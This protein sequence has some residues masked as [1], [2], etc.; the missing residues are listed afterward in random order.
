M[1]TK[2]L[3]PLILSVVAVFAYMACEEGS[4]G[5]Q[6]VKP[7]VVEHIEGSDL[8]HITLTE[9]AMQRLDVQTS[10][11]MEMSGAKMASKNMNAARL[12][13]RH[14]VVPYSAV[15]Y[16]PKGGT[17]VYVSPEPRLFVRERVEIDFIEGQ[18]ACLKKG[19]ELGV[20]V[21]SVGAA[22]LYGAEFEVG[23]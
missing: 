12:R 14:K 5:H 3:Y 9:K 11:V 18:N 7:A 22:E 6:M 1:Q 2:N 13:G 21:V 16:D 20:E 4:A 15:I 8:S 17:W 23:H 10:A 19:P